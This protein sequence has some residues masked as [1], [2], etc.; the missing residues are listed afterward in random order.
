VRDEKKAEG[1]AVWRVQMLSPLLQEGLDPAKARQIRARICEETGLSDRSIRRYIARYREKG[2]EGL[3][4]KGKEKT[5]REDPIPPHIL[6]QAILL[7]RE[8]P[9]RSVS[10]IIQILE[11][12]GRVAQGQI[13]RSTLQEKLAQ[14]GYSARHMK[15]YAQSG[16]AAR[17]YQHRYRN[18][19][20][21]KH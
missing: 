11:W 17:R 21:L 16:V 18:K 13:K 10:Q 5:N 15:M 2:F 7:R 3:K 8:V 6:E 12:E 1:I 20:W 14:K 19:L 4:P 9:G